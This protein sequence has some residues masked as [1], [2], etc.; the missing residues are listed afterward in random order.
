MQ[1]IKV[2]T[3]AMPPLFFFTFFSFK[4][5][6][7]NSFYISEQPKLNYEHPSLCDAMLVIC[8]K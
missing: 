6:I 2:N 4:A 7:I 3:N 1:I 8:S 5:E